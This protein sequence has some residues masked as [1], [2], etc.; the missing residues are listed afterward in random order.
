[1][2]LVIPF[3]GTILSSV[4]IVGIILAGVIAGAGLG[5]DLTFFASGLEES[6]RGRPGRHAAA[7]H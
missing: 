2:A 1:M 7:L 3:N 4:L 6:V 5:A